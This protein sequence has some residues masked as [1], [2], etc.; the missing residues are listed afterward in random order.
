MTTDERVE[1]LD[2]KVS[3]LTESLE[4]SVRRQRIT[5]TALVLVAV[6]AAVMAAA[7]QSRDATFNGVSPYPSAVRAS[8]RGAQQA[9]FFVD[10]GA[11]LLLFTLQWAAIRCVRREEAWHTP[12]A[13]RLC[14]GHQCPNKRGSEVVTMGQAGA[15]DEGGAH[16]APA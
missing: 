7:P 14:L 12:I 6:A 10:C 15:H 5:I 13:L 1:A 16:V 8:E 11:P 2:T 9:P 3:K 4:T